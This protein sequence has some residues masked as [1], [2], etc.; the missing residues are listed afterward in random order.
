M[1]KS[2]G[3]MDE[4]I[5]E[6]KKI[7][8]LR[9]NTDIRERHLYEEDMGELPSMPKLLVGKTTPGA[10]VQP[11]NEE[12]VIEI[13]KWANRYNA[14]IIP[15]AAASS[16]YGGVVPVK[17]SV[18]L[19]LIHFNKIIAID[20][21]NNTVTV[22]PGIVW[23]DLEFRLNAKNLSVRLMPTSTPA[24]TVGGWLAQGG[25][26]IGSYSYGWFENNVESAAVILPDGTKKVLQSKELSLISGAMGTTGIITSITL[27]I[28]AF[29]KYVPFAIKAETPS[30]VQELI[31]LI[32]QNNV[33]LWHI[34]FFNPTASVLKNKVPPKT[35]QG[36][37]EKRPILP[38][39]YIIMTAC[40][41]SLA[42]AAEKKLTELTEKTGA[43][44][45]SR[46]ISQHEWEDRFNPM[47][48]KRI[49]PSIVP[50]EVLVPLSAASMVINEINALVK[51]LVFIEATMINKNEVVLL[52]L[53]PHDVRKFTFNLAFTLSLSIL[54]IAK[55]YGG[56]AYA[57]GLYLA[58]EANKVHGTKISQWKHFKKE[59]DP[60]DIFNPRKLSGI[61][62]MNKM[63]S[64][65][66]MFEPM[67]RMVGNRIKPKLKEE[68][69][70]KKG[71]PGDVVWYAYSCAKCGYCRNVCTLYDGKGW[72][73]S[74][75]RG[76]WAF[77]RR[78][79]E[80]KDKFDQEMTDKFLMCTTCERCDFVCQLDLP[81]EPS[82]GAMRGELV[83][84][85][86]Q[87]TFPAF[88]LMASSARKEKN[89]WAN[90]S[91]DR[92]KWIPEDIKP[93]IKDKADI[94]YFAGCTA[95]FVENDISQ[96]SVRL[97]DAAGVEFTTL[98]KDEAC[99]GI[100]ML[101]S[102]RWDV[103]EEI[104]RHNVKHMK[105]HEAKTVVTSCPACWLVWNNIYP[106]WAKK[107]GIEYNFKAKHYSEII[108]DKLKKGELKFTKPVNMKLTF[109]DSCHIG[110][111]GG[112]YEPPREMLKAIPGVELVEM[113]HNK[114]NSLC[115]GSVLTRISEPNPTSN[116][117]GKKKL[118]EA[119]ATGADAIVALCPC[120]QFQMRVSAKE[121][122][123][124]L[125]V[126]DL[127]AI[128]AK[129]LGIDLPDYTPYALEMW[130]VFEKVIALMQ[131]PNMSKLMTKLIPNMMDAL[132]PPLRGMMGLV[133][134]PGMDKIFKPLMPKMMPILMPMLMPKV[135]PD[136]LREVESMI[137][138]P[139]FMRQ[140]MPDLMPKTMDNMLPHVLPEIAVIVTPAMIQY[141]KT[142]KLPSTNIS[143]NKK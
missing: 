68:W 57:S 14:P 135:M 109:H 114:E 138:M 78:V 118:D 108:V 95:A 33:P 9:I 77:I 60:K 24:A 25:G 2:K 86:K 81:I 132:P 117:L 11:Q 48:I 72:E 51:P 87:M 4:A 107:L 16:G 7:E 44:M 62:L 84:T 94:A 127:A 93:K 104:L 142:K 8:A 45:L 17:G 88:E 133:K 122:N 131:V 36:H 70:S 52:C 64:M 119:V 3:L 85:G 101:V 134:V 23:K 74:S 99:C 121:N 46:E 55:S 136:M 80:G 115:C 30:M 105:E 54:K 73:S 22:E 28:K 126:K 50:A 116:L 100:P 42:K 10:I 37:I 91:K 69:K 97:L 29:E 82:W 40:R 83:N 113:E 31:K 66:L 106:E 129:G 92:D 58:S 65:T 19:E 34:G 47:K 140:Q 71:V 120:C 79:A 1:E 63:I 32:G 12:Q 67:V 110:R 35:H 90:F 125:P 6:L 141:I 143:L 20:E 96:A 53:I 103:F 49:G 39:A 111:A 128:S 59:M 102:G 98:G 137:Q 21:K 18:V 43:K 56:R 89:I 112:V 139:D 5:E 13:V 41:E 27:R 124:D 123:I 76:K 15:R 130:S 75:P 26:G 61:W 38:E